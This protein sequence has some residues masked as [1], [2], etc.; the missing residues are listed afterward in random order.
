MSHGPL[1]TTT[2]AAALAAAAALSLPAA[3]RDDTEAAGRERA[4]PPP[5]LEWLAPA[6][7]T[8]PAQTDAEKE[9]GRQKGRRL[10]APEVLQPT[11]D[12]ALEPYRTLRARKLSGRFRGAASDVLPSLVRAWIDGFRKHYPDV[13]LEIAPPYAGS[14]GAKELVKETLDFV[15]VSRELRPDDVTEFV[16]RFGYEPLSVP[17]AGGSYRH[18]G[19]L[20]TIVFFVHPDNPLQGVTFDQLDAIYSST[21][22]RGG[23]PITRWG[24]L[25]L[26]GEWSEKPINAYGIQPWNGFEEFVRQRVLSLPGRRGEWKSDVRFDKV[27]FPVAKRV[28]GDRLGIGYSGLAYIDAAVRILPVAETAG[29]P[30]HPPTYEAVARAE[31]PLGRLV[32]FNTN[33]GPGRPLAPALDEFLRFVLSRDGQQIVLDHAI[34][35]PLREAQARTGRA[36]LGARRLEGP[37]G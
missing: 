26:E 20:D 7:A 16:A 21:R 29:G 33:R 18:Y 3:S 13:S 1:H 6:A 32:Y 15:F 14:L 30:Y 11:L 25:G 22:N 24:Q 19:F 10:P 35:L 23:A 8:N 9:E 2:W 36:L 17:I 34:F 28:S 12:R 5:M 27:V 37:V 4:V 31:Y